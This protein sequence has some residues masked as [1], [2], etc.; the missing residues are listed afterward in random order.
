MHKWLALLAVSIAVPAAAQDIATKDLV[1]RENAI[2]C[3]LPDNVAAANERA[4]AKS[5]TVLAA[6]GCLRSQAGIRTEVVASTDQ[7]VLQVRFYPAGISTG[8]TLWALP[9]ALVPRNTASAR[10]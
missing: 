3:M 5:Q 6:M 1:T 9:T 4:V 7:A 2:L 8:V 10:L